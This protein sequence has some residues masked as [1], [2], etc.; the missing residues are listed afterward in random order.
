M[1]KWMV[2]L[3]FGLWAIVFVMI[4]VRY[5]NTGHMSVFLVFVGVSCLLSLASHV[6]R[7]RVVRWLL[8]SGGAAAIAVAVYVFFRG[9]R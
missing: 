7:R 3:T 6:A 2:G 4:A 8:R 5:V 1:N 9:A